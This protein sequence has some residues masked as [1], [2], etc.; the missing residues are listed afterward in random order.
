MSRGSRT[1]IATRRTS[2]SPTSSARTGPA[3]LRAPSG[4]A[5][6]VP[7]RRYR[8]RRAGTTR[9]VGAHAAQ[10][11]GRDPAAERGSG[12]HTVSRSGGRR[13]GDHCAE[14]RSCTE[15][16]VVPTV[17]ISPTISTPPPTLPPATGPLPDDPVAH[18]PRWSPPTPRLGA[19]RTPSRPDVEVSRSVNRNVTVPAGRSATPTPF[20]AREKPSKPARAEHLLVD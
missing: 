1:W 17:P 20:S 7:D 12:S 13:P 15:P 6:L 3:G 16:V 14:R 11:G 18:G 8:R 4:P 5:R 10:G 2:S 19:A 9:G